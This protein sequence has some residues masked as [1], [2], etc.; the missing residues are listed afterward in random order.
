MNFNLLCAVSKKSPAALPAKKSL[1]ICDKGI[2]G[3]VMSS[4]PFHN[5]HLCL[6][7]ILIHSVFILLIVSS[8]TQ[9]FSLCSSVYSITI[10]CD[11]ELTYNKK[12]A[13]TEPRHM[14][15]CCHLECIISTDIWDIFFHFSNNRRPDLWTSMF[16]AA[17][18]QMKTLFESM[19]FIDR[20]YNYSHI[21]PYVTQIMVLEKYN[22]VWV[23]KLYI[24]H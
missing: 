11:S 24:H 12:K 7:Y 18:I 13:G 1:L 20:K 5:T 6:C 23:I 4:F 10:R 21:Y 22:S 15:A 2:Q 16:I 9:S 8:S 19:I 3:K 17:K 14:K